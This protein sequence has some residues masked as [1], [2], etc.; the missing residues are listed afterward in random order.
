MALKELFLNFFISRKI[1]VFCRMMRES[2]EVL[3]WVFKW[4]L[5]MDF[6]WWILEDLLSVWCVY[7][8]ARIMG[9]TEKLC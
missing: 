2:G 1:S 7:S 8:V 5:M 6:S 9:N 3:A 4:V